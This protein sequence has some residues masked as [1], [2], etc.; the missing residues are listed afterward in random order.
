MKARYLALLVV[1]SCAGSSERAPAGER[2]TSE[3]V[4]FSCELPRDWA[5][6]GDRGAILFTSTAHAK[7][8]IAVRVVPLAGADAAKVL[9][10]TRVAI[11][12][13]PEVRRTDTR[14][15]DGDLDCTFYELSFVPPGLRSRYARTHVVLVGEHHVFHVIETAPAGTGRDDAIVANLIASFREE[16]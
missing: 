1:A 10:A 14:V 11:E 4:P 8:T 7:R 13:L 16:G 6:H 12:R 2:F 3:D 15:V 5:A 9:D